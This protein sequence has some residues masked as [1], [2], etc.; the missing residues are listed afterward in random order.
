[1]KLK[2]KIDI[3]LLEIFKTGKFNYLKLGQTK[4]WILNNFPDPD[5]YSVD[6]S[7]FE[8]DVW[9]YGDIELH[10]RKDSTLFLIF[11]NHI[12]SL[13]GGR[14][15]SLNKWILNNPKYL[16]LEKLLGHLVLER[17]DF[18]FNIRACLNLYCKIVYS[19][20]LSETRLPIVIGMKT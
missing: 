17:I 16:A 15:L 3:D 10:F 19:L 5:N 18:I 12:D 7:V 13:E 8:N 1:M 4:E 14:S 11:T 2:T 6:A 9:C 20:F